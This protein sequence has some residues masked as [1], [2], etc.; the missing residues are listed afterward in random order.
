MFSLAVDES[1]M[2]HFLLLVMC[3]VLF[4]LFLTEVLMNTKTETADLKWTVFPNTKP[5]VS[6]SSRTMLSLLQ[7][8]TL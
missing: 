7:T 2:C 8:W 6:N 4:H 3:V 1:Q 5:E